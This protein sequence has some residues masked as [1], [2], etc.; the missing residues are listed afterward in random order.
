MILLTCLHKACTSA[1]IKSHQNFVVLC[2]DFML[3]KGQN[4]I[5][6]HYENKEDLTFKK[7]TKETKKY[8]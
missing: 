5:F 2:E 1:Q 3:F 7:A 6:V 4:Y 8:L